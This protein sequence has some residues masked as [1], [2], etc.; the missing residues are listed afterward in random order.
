MGDVVIVDGARTAHGELLGALSEQTAVDLG[1]TAVQGL[2]DRNGPGTDRIDWVCLG[3]SVQA[4]VGQVPARQVVVGTDLT[5]DV[6]ATT[7]NEASGSGLRAITTAVDR[8]DAG[9]AEMCVAGGMES[10]SNAPYLV[11]DMRGGRRYGDTDLVDAMLYDSLWD[12]GYDAHMGEL[13]ERLVAEY[14]VDREAQDEYALRSNRHAA[15]AIEDGVFD[16]EIVPVEADDHLVNEDEGPRSDTSLERLGT[17]PPAFRDG[18]TITAG[19]AS[20]LAD[21]AGAVLMTDAEVAADAGLGPMAHV[22]DYAVAYRDPAEFGLAVIDAVDD[23][24]ERNDLAP[25][26]VDHFE[27]NEAFAAQTV[28][29]RDELGIAEET[30]NPLGGA[31]ALGHPIGASGGILTTTLVHAME[32]EDHDRGV[33]GM[34]VGGGGG[35]AMLLRR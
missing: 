6:A 28:L 8:I 30:L 15:E 4:G 29:A 34:S 35:V 10:M 18:G 16:P 14:D 26:D 24:L 5:D 33:V 11:R 17:L 2:L 19:N 13:T 9:R 1:E 3:N 31:V 32:R 27:L 25:G 7:V 23:L 20:K 22:V 21:G 12:V